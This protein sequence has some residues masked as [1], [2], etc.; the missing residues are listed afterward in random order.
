[1]QH[2][3]ESQPSARRFHSM[4]DFAATVTQPKKQPLS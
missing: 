1:M 4:A 2:L 3:C